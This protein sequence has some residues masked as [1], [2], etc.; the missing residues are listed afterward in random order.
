MVIH[1]K[2]P[3]EEI[4]ESSPSKKAKIDDS[5]RKEAMPTLEI[6]MTKSN[7]GR[8]KIP[9]GQLLERAPQP[10]LA[11]CWDLEPLS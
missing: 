8:A 4:S 11:I 5:K 7:K 6:K 3:R 1:E 9:S 10:N 2:R